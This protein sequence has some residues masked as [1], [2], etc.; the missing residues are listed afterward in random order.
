MICSMCLVSTEF[1]GYA[2][3]H[4]VTDPHVLA[5]DI[6]HH[7]FRK[8]R[9]SKLGCVIGCSPGECVCTGHATY[10]DDVTSVLGSKPE[11]SFTTAIEGSVQIRLHRSLPLF[12]RKFTHTLKDT[13][14]GIVD[15]HIERA[16]LGIDEAE[17]LSHLLIASNIGC[18]PSDFTGGFGGELCHRTIDIFLPLTTYRNGRAF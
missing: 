2:T 5:P 18:F 1:G 9:Q 8:T 16:E 17:Q 3:R 14:A 13:D 11:Q 10:I 12:N 6:L 7:C 4:D 15:Q